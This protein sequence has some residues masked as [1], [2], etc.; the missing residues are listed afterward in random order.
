MLKI[1]PCFV[2]CF[3][4]LVTACAGSTPF[5]PSQTPAPTETPVPTETPP[6]TD[7]PHP[8]PEWELVWADE[9]DLPDGSPPDSANW[10]HAIGGH[11]W[12]NNEWQFYT[13]HIENAF[14]EDGA[15]VIEAIQETHR[16]ADYTSARIHTQGKAEFLYGRF[17][18]RAKLPNTQGIWPAIWMMPAESKYGEWPLS[19]EIDIMEMIGRDPY[20]VHGTI[21]YGDPKGS[22]TGSYFLPTYESFDQDFHLFV[23]EWEPDE[24]RWY[25]DGELFYTANYWYTSAPDAPEGAPF[26]QPFY[27][28]LNVAVGGNWP[29]YPNEGSEFPQRMTVDFVRVYQ[30]K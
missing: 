24:F 21:H 4:T 5:A 20:L 3:L 9:F 19:G 10:N 14:I 7:I 22:F 29:G 30:K 1:H 27:W 12:G 17:E 28:I 6:P 18:A 2:A 11:G 16:G 25:V 26:D 15:L 13:D 8:G 23:M